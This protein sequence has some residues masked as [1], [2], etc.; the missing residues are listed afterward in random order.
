[1]LYRPF[2]SFF[3]PRR[4]STWRT[5]PSWREMERLRREMD[6]LFTD[7]SPR[8]DWTAAPAYPAMNVWINEDGAIVTAELP[9]VAPEDIEISVVN[10]T[11]TVTGT[12]Q[13]E[14]VEGATY[15][16]RERSSGKFTR[17][18]QLPFRIE[19]NQVEASFERG[20]LHI[21]LPRAEADKPKRI[22]VKAG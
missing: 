10:E 8:S 11:L 9:G 16:R 19:G 15:H 22:T 20:V 3:A 6:R 5:N 4:G 7:W 17:S 13:P 2:D 1:M 21:H 18:F 14:E 12:R